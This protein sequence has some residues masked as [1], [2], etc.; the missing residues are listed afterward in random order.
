MGLVVTACLRLGCF[1]SLT[2]QLLAKQASSPILQLR[3]PE[4]HKH[5][6][7]KESNLCKLLQV[8]LSSKQANE[9]L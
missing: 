1:V 2:Y 5:L 7:L 3:E 4:N 9:T 8:K 6:K